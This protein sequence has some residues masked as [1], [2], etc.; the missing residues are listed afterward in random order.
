MDL[1]PGLL[2]I[3]AQTRLFSDGQ[4]YIVASLP[5]DRVNE[6]ASLLAQAAVPFSAL[7][8]DKDELT[9]VLPTGLWPE[10]R[11]TLPIAQEAGV[12]RLITFDLPLELG[13]VGYIATM[14]N[15]LAEAGVSLLAFSAYQRDH[16][17]V[18]TDDMT[19][20]WE[21]LSTFIAACR[22]QEQQG[23]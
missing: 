23:N 4:E 13:L 20:A 7:L 8:V 14:A 11:R 17:L 18:P 22:E 12:Y 15:V 21:A 16:L 3:L 1:P 2:H 10:A 9:L 5:L 19:R 6:G